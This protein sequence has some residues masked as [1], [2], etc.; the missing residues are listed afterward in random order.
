MGLFSRRGGGMPIYNQNAARAEQTWAADQARKYG[1]VGVNSALGGY[2]WRTNPDGTQTVDVHHSDADKARMNHI[3]NALGSLNMDPSSARANAYSMMT[4][5]M[6]RDFNEQR[7][8]YEQDLINKGIPIGS[9]AY[10]KAMGRLSD[11]HATALGSAGKQAMFAGQDYVQN[12]INQIGSLSSQINNPLNQMVSGTGGNFGGTYDNHFNA[13]LNRYNQKQAR[14][15][16][17]FGA[18]GSLAGAGIG[19]ALG[20]PVGMSAGSGFGGKLGSGF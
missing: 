18:L 19:A 17:L 10:N 12:Q 14:R 13:Q 20:G 7:Q 1:N 8:S 15:S 9:E 16:G 2:S 3:N 4:E 11:S 5:G 6:N